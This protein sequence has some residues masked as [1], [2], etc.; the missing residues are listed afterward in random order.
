M[1]TKKATVS[2]APITTGILIL[3]FKK[4]TT[5]CKSIAKSIDN[6]K[7]IIISCPI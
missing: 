2:T 5:G 6:S 4:Y 7:G 1:A 3:S